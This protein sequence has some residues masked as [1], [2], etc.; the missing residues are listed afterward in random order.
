MTLNR[1][2]LGNYQLKTQNKSNQTALKPFTI[3]GQGNL[4][5][6]AKQRFD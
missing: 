6:V 3:S 2:L 4:R 5:G 1:R